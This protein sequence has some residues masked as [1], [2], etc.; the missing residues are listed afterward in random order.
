[1]V[2]A[3][4]HEFRTVALSANTS[5]GRALSGRVRVSRGGYFNGDRSSVSVSGVWRVDYH[6]A[7]DFSAE[8]N[9]ITLPGLETFPASVYGGRA[10]F[11]ASTRFFTSAFVQYNALTNEVVSN[12]RL[13]YVHAPLSDLFLVFT[14]RR[15]RSGA[16]PPDRLLSLKVTR[17]F[18][19]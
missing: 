17:A 4:D 16:T 14:E 1:V 12:V 8:R 2:P 13:N 3:G 5:A 19:F 11:A 15:D 7:L 18:A 6:L 10:T 9:A